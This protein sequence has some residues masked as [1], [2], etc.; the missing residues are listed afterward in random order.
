[1]RKV[2]TGLL[3]LILACIGAGVG[4]LLALRSGGSDDAGRARQ[5]TTRYV[6]QI[7]YGPGKKAGKHIVL[8]FSCQPA[9]GNVPDPAKLCR[10]IDARPESFFASR[11]D[12]FCIGG[13]PALPA[14]IRVRGTYRGNFVGRRE[15]QGCPMIHSWWA[16]ANDVPRVEAATDR[17]RA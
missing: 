4:A 7:D 9:R 16:L 15:T 1:V 5:A 10:R 6:I 14:T 2:G 8:R 3:L 17:S 12:Q 13:G 11:A